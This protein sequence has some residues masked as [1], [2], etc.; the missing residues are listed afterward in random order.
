[1]WKE[2]EQDRGQGSYFGFFQQT[3]YNHLMANVYPIESANS[4]DTRFSR[5]VIFDGYGLGILNNS[6]FF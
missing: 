4:N 2:G 1:M 6:L 3:A 5:F